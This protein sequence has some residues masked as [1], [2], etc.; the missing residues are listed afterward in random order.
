MGEQETKPAAEGA[1]RPTSYTPVP[2]QSLAGSAVYEQ[3]KAE[4]RKRQRYQKLRKAP[5]WIE[6]GAAI[7]LVAI[8]WTYTHYAGKQAAA[9]DKTL[10]EII[11]QFPEIQKSAKA[12]ADANVA[13]HD[14]L[15]RSNRPWIGVESARLTAPITFARAG[16]N[17]DTLYVVS[18]GIEI[19]V[20]NFGNSPA[21]SVSTFIE[22]YDPSLPQGEKFD[23]NNPF[24]RLQKFGE[25]VCAIADG[26]EFTKRNPRVY[27]GAIF[28]TQ[29]TVYDSGILGFATH[30][31]EIGQFIQLVGCV[32]YLDQFG[33]MT[34]HT[35]Y[36]LIAPVKAMSTMNNCQ[37][38]NHAD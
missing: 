17:K 23:I 29:V 9:A 7:A 22:A 8:T 26:N 38:N 2:D 24:S 11:K 28:P 33:E 21:L 31:F 3:S 30:E 12:A 18:G 37:S 32:S 10:G 19:S 13:A 35:H 4:D 6:A 34:H 27:G 25:S 36:C 20:K 14:A 1:A 16:S 5:I 15:T